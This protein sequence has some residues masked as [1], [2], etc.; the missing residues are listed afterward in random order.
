MAAPMLDELKK[1]VAA[2]AFDR[3]GV[4]AKTVIPDLEAEIAELTAKVARLEA[5][6]AA[7]E[8]EKKGEYPVTDKLNRLKK[9]TGRID[10]LGTD[11]EPG[12]RYATSKR[13]KKDK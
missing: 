6:K 9:M 12:Y 3:A 4:L 8:E 5:E 10:K 13:P 2:G 1:A 11:G 7:K